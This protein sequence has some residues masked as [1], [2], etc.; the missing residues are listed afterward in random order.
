MPEQQEN[1]LSDPRLKALLDQGRERGQ[2]TYQDINQ[3]IGQLAGDDELV[4]EAVLEELDRVGVELVEETGPKRPDKVPSDLD[5]VLQSLEDLLERSGI[6]YTG[7]DEPEPEETTEATRAGIEDA[8]QQY[9]Q[10]MGRI[11]LLTAEEE[12]SLARQMRQ[13]SPEARDA[14]RQKLV[15]SN[16]RLVVF[17]A[18]KYSRQAAL[19]LMDIIQEGNFGLIRAVQRFDPDRGHRLSTYATWW[20][21]Q[22]INRAVADQNRS[23]R[24]PGI[25]SGKIQKVLRVQ[26]E[27]VQDL[28]RQPTRAE[29]AQ[30][31]G[32]TLV[33][34]EEVL[35]A[36][37]QPV[38]LESPVGDE[39]DT[40]LGDTLPDTNEA[41]AF[42]AMNRHEMA[43]DLEAAM[44]HLND[45]EKAVV[46]RRFGLVDYA[47]TGPQTLEDV[48][49]A[50]NLSRER[51]RQL[52]LQAMRKLRR[53]TRSWLA[54]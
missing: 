35:R 28:G 17:M 46:C 6:H 23:M 10:R 45:R 5:E 27:L 44:T 33:Q 51:V 11:P 9:V 43:R 21:R 18:R 7:Y 14:A 16:L 54:E 47:G 13:G 24:L 41:G 38:S 53:H 12:A 34:L 48:A 30:A 25:L 50:M 4:M 29:V 31:T 49:I 26:R 36:S 42:A 32:L 40:E 39:Q 1:V 2:L 19:P 3:V 22:A 20:I 52:E 15:E 37:Y 8:Y